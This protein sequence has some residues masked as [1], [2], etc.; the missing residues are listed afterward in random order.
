MHFEKTIIL[1]LKAMYT[2]IDI[3]YTFYLISLTI[4]MLD[5]GKQAFVAN[6]ED[7][8]EMLLKTKKGSIS[9]EFALFA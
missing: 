1:F 3:K 9:S 2:S 6:R 4:F 5:P 8:G 7:P